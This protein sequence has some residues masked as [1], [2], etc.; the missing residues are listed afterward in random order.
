MAVRGR[1]SGRRALGRLAGEA[2]AGL[3]RARAFVAV[4][5]ETGTVFRKVREGV[6][7]GR[8]GG[9]GRGFRGWGM[10]TG[11]RGRYGSGSLS[12][13]R[14][15]PEPAPPLPS[16]V[17]RFP[18][19]G[20]DPHPERPSS[21][22]VPWAGSRRLNRCPG[23]WPDGGGLQK[24]RRGRCWHKCREAQRGAWAALPLAPRLR[25]R[26]DSPPSRV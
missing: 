8:A 14:A 13:S 7:V 2:G 6:L 24:S 17:S 5:E 15:G 12:D 18:E 4:M 11:R 16:R 19:S 20:N 10:C 3:Q 23:L 25:E 1:G 26:Q 21:S 22:V 9:C